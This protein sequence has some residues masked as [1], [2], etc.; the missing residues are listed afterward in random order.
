M[1]DFDLSMR[2]DSGG[3]GRTR[4]VTTIRF[5]IM[6]LGILLADRC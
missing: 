2:L 5:L 3:G 6:T 1:T 4:W